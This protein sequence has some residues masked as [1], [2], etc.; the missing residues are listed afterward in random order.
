MYKRISF[1]SWLTSVCL[2]L[3]LILPSAVFAA[4]HKVEAVGE[5]ILENGLDEDV[6]VVRDRALEK[7]MRNAAFQVGARV[8]GNI[9]TQNHKYIAGENEIRASKTLKVNDQQYTHETVEEGVLYRCHIVAMVDDTELQALDLK[10]DDIKQEIQLNRAKDELNGQMKEYGQQMRTANTEAHRVQIRQQVKENEAKFAA[11]RLVEKAREAYD[12]KDYTKAMMYCNMAIELDSKLLDA[13]FVLGDTYFQLRDFN[14]AIDNYQKMIPLV[15]PGGYGHEYAS[16][17][18]VYYEMGDYKKAIEC[19]SKAI[20]DN[21]YLYGSYLRVGDVY[22]NLEKVCFAADEGYDKL[23]KAYERAINKRI[24][25][26]YL[27]RL[28]LGE[29]YIK[30]G[31]YDKAIDCYSEAISLFPDFPDAYNDRGVAY[32]KLGRRKEAKQDY[33]KAYE[34]DTRNEMYRKNKQRSENW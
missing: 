27:G 11:I 21:P 25:G 26:P 15:P 20:E 5:W 10:E 31:A 23:I 19:Y 32:E 17:G 1:S 33:A 18:N 29:I 12:A 6:N 2:A 28:Q 3:F 22:K 13:Y 16:L 8:D 24:K 4:V 14:N 9:S 34:R 7:A 30:M